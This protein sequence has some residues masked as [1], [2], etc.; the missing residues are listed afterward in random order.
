MSRKPVFRVGDR[1]K[2]A[3][4]KWVRRVGYPLVANE[5]LAE[6]QRDLRTLTAFK[7][8][9]P[10]FQGELHEIPYE[11]LQTIARLR[12]RQRRFGGN[13][14]DVYYHDLS[15]NHIQ[16]WRDAIRC[17]SFTVAEKRVVQTGLRDWIGEDEGYCFIP[18][19]TYVMVKLHTWGAYSIP[20]V[21]HELPR[22]YFHWTPQQQHQ[23]DLMNHYARVKKWEGLWISGEYLCH[24]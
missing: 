14:R 22:E 24:A 15:E 16:Y 1:V 19:K 17:R 11:F 9:C 23:Y 6:V 12:V 10:E 7:M 20:P 2:V 5:L 8:V 3:E 21:Y 4:P 13:R 18:D